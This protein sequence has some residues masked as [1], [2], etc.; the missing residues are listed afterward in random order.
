MKVIEAV[1]AQDCFGGRAV[2]GGSGR[3]RFRPPVEG[4]FSLVE[5]KATVVPFRPCLFYGHSSNSIPPAASRK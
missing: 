1:V 2:W 3:V 4:T 5:V